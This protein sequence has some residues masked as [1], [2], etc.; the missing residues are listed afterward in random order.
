MRLSESKDVVDKD[1]VDNDQPFEGSERESI[2][3]VES[4]ERRMRRT[5]AQTMQVIHDRV[6]LLNIYPRQTK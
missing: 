5:F 4:A 1:V 6:L 2:T 3:V